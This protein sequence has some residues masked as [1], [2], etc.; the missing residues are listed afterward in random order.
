MD[1][2][3]FTLTDDGESVATPCVEIVAGSETVGTY[4]QVLQA[5]VWKEVIVAGSNLMRGQLLRE[6][7]LVYEKRD[8]LTPETREEMDIAVT[9]GALVGEVGSVAQSDLDQALNM[10]VGMIAGSYPAYKAAQLDPDFNF[11]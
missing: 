10:G 11:R 7:D 8:L 6:A 2:A 1:E 9:L 3:L 4:Q 5:R